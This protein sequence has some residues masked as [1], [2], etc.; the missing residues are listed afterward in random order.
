[1]LIE[2]LLCAVPVLLPRENQ[3]QGISQD[4]TLPGATSG[5]VALAPGTSL[6][7]SVPSSGGG[8]EHPRPINIAGTCGGAAGRGRAHSRS[9]SS[10]NRT[11]PGA[12]SGS[13]KPRESVAPARSP[14]LGPMLLVPT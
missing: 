9:P 7:V 3:E 8:D 11:P 5:R 12:V 2:H 4:V 13:A 6:Q 1:M 10:R 14:R